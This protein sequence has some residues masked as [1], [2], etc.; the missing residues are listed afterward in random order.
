M[1]ELDLPS[2]RILYRFAQFH[3]RRM[4]V[5]RSAFLD[6]L[7]RVQVRCTVYFKGPPC[8]MH[9]IWD[10]TP[11]FHHPLPRKSYLLH[12]G[13]TLL[14]AMLLS[15]TMETLTSTDV[16]ARE[17]ART[18]AMMCPNCAQDDLDVIFDEAIPNDV[19][20]KVYKTLDER[21]SDVL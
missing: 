3:E 19:L 21:F 8:D 20:A 16:D 7:D 14:R 15:P 17:S 11:Q 1:P 10:D 5:I 13:A 4:S 18:I 6:M 9:D 12:Y 2:L